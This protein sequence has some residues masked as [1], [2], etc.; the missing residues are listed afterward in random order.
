MIIDTG[1]IEVPRDRQ[2]TFDPQQIA[3]YQRRLPSFDDKIISMDA[4]GL[5]TRE[6]T[7]HLR[8][9]NGIDAS[10]DLISVLTD[11]RNPTTDPG[12]VAVMYRGDD[13]TG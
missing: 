10:P 12:L 4:R 2:S 6:I 8:E 11:L 7:G 5:T 9:L 13:Q 3:K 1:K